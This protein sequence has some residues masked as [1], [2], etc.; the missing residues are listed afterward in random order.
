MLLY[1][2]CTVL[3]RENQEVIRAFLA[4][5]SQFA[6]EGFTLLGPVGSVEEG[7][8]TLW[9]HLYGTDGFFICKLRK[10]ESPCN[11]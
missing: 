7:M 2:T 4:E 6:P 9:P 1:S 3:E 11:G 10:G 5:N 8:V